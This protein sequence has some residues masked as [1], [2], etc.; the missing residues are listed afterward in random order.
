MTNN[1][2]VGILSVNKF[3]S[4]RLCVTIPVTKYAKV[5]NKTITQDGGE[6]TPQETVMGDPAKEELLYDQDL[7]L[8]ERKRIIYEMAV[9]SG[10]EFPEAVV[11][12]YQLE[13]TSGEDNIGTNNIF[14][15][16]A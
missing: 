4:L 16:K 12:Q 11:A 9:K 10:A 6:V 2:N 1:N 7:P 15:L 14:N 5:K 8:E 3:N 13:T